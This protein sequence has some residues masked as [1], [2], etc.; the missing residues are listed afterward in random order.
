MA[1]SE[2][3]D[4]VGKP[5]MSMVCHHGSTY[6][7]DLGIK[8]DA[9]FV[10]KLSPKAVQKHINRHGDCE[11]FEGLGEI[12]VCDLQDDGV[13]IICETKEACRCV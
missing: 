2:K 4:G 3:P 12:Q 9:T 8:E 13:T 7:S 11:E 5:E 10:I 1:F 6:N